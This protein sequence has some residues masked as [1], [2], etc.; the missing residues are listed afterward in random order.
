MHLDKGRTKHPRVLVDWLGG[1]GINFY[2][3]TDLV[4]WMLLLAH[5]W[6]GEA[7]LALLI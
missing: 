7:L 6:K 5:L 3:L 2:L 1:K 4:G